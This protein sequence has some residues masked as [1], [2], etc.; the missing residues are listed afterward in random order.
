MHKGTSTKQSETRIHNLET[1]IGNYNQ[2][3]FDT[4]YSKL[5]T[6]SLTLMKDSA[7]H[8][9]KTIV[10]TEHNTKDTETHWKNI[11]EREEYQ[12]IEKKPSKTMKQ[13]PN[14][15]CNKD[16]S[17]KFNDLKYKPNSTT[18][19]TLKPTKHKIGFQKIYAS[20][21]QGTNNFNVKYHS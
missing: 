1:T 11:T 3:F 18:D 7:A 16:S 5:K 12:S 14:V 19:E 17:K 4:W 8:C 10:K 2:K 6:F 9:D 21:V 15:S 20:V 13:T